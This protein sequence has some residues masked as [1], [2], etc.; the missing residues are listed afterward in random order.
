MMNGMENPTIEDYGNIEAE[1]EEEAIDI[2]LDYKYPKWW[3]YNK[4]S[5]LRHVVEFWKEHIQAIKINK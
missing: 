5:N 3:L 1:S 2:C 4:E